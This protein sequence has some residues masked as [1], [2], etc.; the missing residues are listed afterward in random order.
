MLYLDNPRNGT[1]GILFCVFV[2][3]LYVLMRIVYAPRPSAKPGGAAQARSLH[4]FDQTICFLYD[5]LSLG[6]P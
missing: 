1:D 3:I 5:P 2:Y 6:P 4:G